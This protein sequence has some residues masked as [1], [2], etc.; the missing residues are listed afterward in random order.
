MTTRFQSFDDRLSTL[1][2]IETCSGYLDRTEC[3]LLSRVA[4]KA[5]FLVTVSL[6][7]LLILGFA[8]T[9]RKLG[10]RGITKPQVSRGIEVQR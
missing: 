7:F 8:R 2:V 9:K 10:A 5:V 4:R 6:A 1:R 3:S